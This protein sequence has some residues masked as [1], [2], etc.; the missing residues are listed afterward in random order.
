MY[1]RIY[2][3]YP[4]KLSTKNGHK[5][6]VALQSRYAN[7]SKKFDFRPAMAATIMFITDSFTYNI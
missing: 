4:A 2:F 6:Q 3:E 1:T 7:T 5:K